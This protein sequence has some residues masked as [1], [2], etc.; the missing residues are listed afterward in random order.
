MCYTDYE[1]NWNPFHLLNNVIVGDSNASTSLENDWV[2]VSR[3]SRDERLGYKD[4]KIVYE[5]R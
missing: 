5:V 4:I 1:P 3:G 2:R